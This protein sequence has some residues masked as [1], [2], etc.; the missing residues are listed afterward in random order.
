MERPLKIIGR[1]GRRN[2]LQ[3]R[4]NQDSNSGGGDL[5]PTELSVTPL[6]H[7]QRK[8]GNLSEHHFPG[9]RISYY[10]SRK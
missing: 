6:R 5:L 3:R 7:P 8:E 1:T 9:S 2:I 4:P 10:I